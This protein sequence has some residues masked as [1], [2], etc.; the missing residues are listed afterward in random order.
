MFH[1]QLTGLCCAYQS[2]N[3]LKKFGQPPSRGQPPNRFNFQG[4]DGTA[5]QS[6]DYT[7]SSQRHTSI[8]QMPVPTTGSR[9]ALTVGG[10]GDR[11]HLSLSQLLITASTLIYPQWNHVIRS[12]AEWRRERQ[13]TE[14][15]EA[16]MYKSLMDNALK[17]KS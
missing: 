9:T 7:E 14:N 8:D 3:H 1:I 6:V 17:P 11:L 4:G 5:S 2:F 16:E 12:P 13:M 10:D 15:A